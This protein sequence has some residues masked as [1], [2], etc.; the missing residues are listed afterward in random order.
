MSTPRGGRG[1][2]L[3]LLLQGDNPFPIRAI[4]KGPRTWIMIQGN[5]INPCSRC[6]EKAL[7]GI[8]PARQIDKEVDNDLRAWYVLAYDTRS[9]CDCQA[10]L[11]CRENRVYGIIDLVQYLEV[12]AG[13]A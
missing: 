11:L 5:D 9:R 13:I 12:C 6:L 7:Y 8:F 10:C 1:A 2:A 3:D 4:G